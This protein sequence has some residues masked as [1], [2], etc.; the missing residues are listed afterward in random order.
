[1]KW[2][3]NFSERLNLI[4]SYLRRCGNCDSRQRCKN[5]ANCV[6]KSASGVIMR[7]TKI[8][9]HCKQLM[10]INVN[11]WKEMSRQ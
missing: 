4:D 11:T 3:F 9:S 8:H 1:M 2:F 10:M 6:I 7:D 5:R